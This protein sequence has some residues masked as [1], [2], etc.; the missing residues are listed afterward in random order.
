MVAAGPVA[1]S[2]EERAAAELALGAA[3]PPRSQ[4]ASGTSAGCEGPGGGSRRG[5]APTARVAGGSLKGG[6]E[7]PETGTPPPRSV[8]P[9]SDGGTSQPSIDRGGRDGNAAFDGG[10]SGGGEGGVEGEAGG[11]ARA[12]DSPP[13]PEEREL[14]LPE[15][16]AT[17]SDDCASEER[18]REP[19]TGA[20]TAEAQGTVA[21]ETAAPTTE[22]VT[23]EQ[24]ATGVADSGAEE[25]PDTETRLVVA[26]P[27]PAQ[28]SN[29]SLVV[30][31]GEP[32]VLLC[33]PMDPA[34]IAPERR[35]EAD[36]IAAELKQAASGGTT[37]KEAEGRSSLPSLPAANE[38]QVMSPEAEP[39]EQPSDEQQEEQQPPQ[40]QQK[41]KQPAHTA[42]HAETNGD[43]PQAQYY[44][45]TPLQIPRGVGCM[46]GP[47]APLGLGG[48]CWGPTAALRVRQ[49]QTAAAAAS[50]GMAMAAA[51][52]VIGFPLPGPMTFNDRRIIKVLAA[53]SETYQRLIWAAKRVPEI[54]LAEAEGEA[55]AMN[56]ELYGSLSLD[57][58]EPSADGKRP[59]QQDWPHYYING[60]SDVDFVV[61]MRPGVTP[62]AVSQ[63]LLAQASDQLPGSQ[64]EPSRGTCSRR[65]WET[66]SWRLV[67]QTHVHKFQSTQYTLLG[68][69][70]EAEDSSSSE[71]YLDVTCIESPL[72]YSRFKSR[73]EA[74]RK[75]FSE[76]RCKMEVQFGALGALAFDA[77]VHLLKAFAAKVP[78]NA[79]TGFQAT[80]I[81]LFTLQLGNFRLK[82]TQS[83]ALS[84]F[85]GF[86]RFCVV[87]FGDRPHGWQAH[88]KSCGIDLCSG[89][90]W[91]PRQSTCWRS[92]LYFMAAEVRMRTR[93]DERV[94]VMHSLDP[95]RVA[96]E[97]QVL[98]TRAYGGTEWGVP[99][100]PQVGPFC[101]P[102]IVPSV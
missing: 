78:G 21:K 98:L 51:A 65:S 91:L 29:D 34:S 7:T 8:S 46:P 54:I 100:V 57:M 75:V 38:P 66:P 87:F 62:Q 26:Q 61:E 14:D 89:G 72:H 82:H 81:G 73:Q 96:Q 97:A 6:L 99:F 67:G 12:A 27:R 31:E 13:Q 84:L 102:P 35:R 37:T 74:F 9:S 44:A 90:R 56:V 49:L 85:E 28:G 79:L 101:P 59:W 10:P 93:P 60:R 76:V 33:T 94:N 3:N 92:E 15:A 48:V 53:P 77:Y 40:P 30:T 19:P 43:G 4:L 17:D 36:R 52:H 86:L 39:A 47:L 16:G 70:S 41:Q 22:G 45:R 80:C 50:S 2:P 42:A 20:A 64:S 83:I 69:C 18:R 1:M 23:S 71:V 24:T 32:E 25:A 58:H 68:S 63:R 5:A 95:C 55:P 11:S 88:H